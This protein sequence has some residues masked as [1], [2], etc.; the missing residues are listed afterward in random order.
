MYI[1]YIIFS[2]GYICGIQYD[3]DPISVKFRISVVGIEDI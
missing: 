3:K 2:L 1:A